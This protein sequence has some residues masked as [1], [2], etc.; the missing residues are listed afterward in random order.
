MS[1]RDEHIALFE[2]QAEG[3]FDLT[4][5]PVPDHE[6]YADPITIYVWIG[7]IAGLQAK[8]AS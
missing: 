2:K 7:F 4:R 1:T 8:E 6:L 3:T 5:K